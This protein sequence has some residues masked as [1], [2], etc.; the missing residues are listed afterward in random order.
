MLTPVV[1]ELYH[2]VNSAVVLPPRWPFERRNRIS[3]FTSDGIV[4]ND[5]TTI[6]EWVNS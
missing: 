3:H 2:S 6:E 4:L 5:G 1:F